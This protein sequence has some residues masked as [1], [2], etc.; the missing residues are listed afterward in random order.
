M[1]FIK[2]LLKIFYFVIYFTIRGRPK[3]SKNKPKQ[4]IKI[5]LGIVF[6][7]KLKII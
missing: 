6:L 7:C 4:L 2:Y 3:D 1:D 5:C